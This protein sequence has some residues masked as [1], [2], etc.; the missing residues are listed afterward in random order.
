MLLLWLSVEL[1]QLQW[2]AS[3]NLQS[4]PLARAC[5]HVCVRACV[6]VCAQ[7]GAAATPFGLQAALAMPQRGLPAQQLLLTNGFATNAAAPAVQPR[8]TIA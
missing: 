6:H 5:V 4:H 3:S 1:V 7:R 8:L 2:L